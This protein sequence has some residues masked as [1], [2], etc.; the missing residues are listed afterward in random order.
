MLLHGYWTSES[1]VPGKNMT[2]FCPVVELASRKEDTG[3]LS[4]D[5]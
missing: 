2:S 4:L 5:N 1:R 3:E